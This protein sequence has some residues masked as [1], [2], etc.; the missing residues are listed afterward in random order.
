M[1]THNDL[2]VYASKSLAIERN[3]L[4]GAQTLGKDTTQIEHDLECARRIHNR[5]AL[6]RVEFVQLAGVWSNDRLFWAFMGREFGKT[7]ENKE[8]AADFIREYCGI[9]SRKQLKTEKEAQRRFLGL[10]QKFKDWKRF[11]ETV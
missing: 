9:I 3:R 2:V 10:K 7:C 11:K 6:Q 1:I 8:T 5:L 4:K